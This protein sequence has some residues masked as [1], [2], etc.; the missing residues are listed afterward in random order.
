[1]TNDE[2]VLP[3]VINPEELAEQKVPGF[4]IEQADLLLEDRL[5]LLPDKE[6]Y[7]AVGYGFRNS[8]IAEIIQTDEELQ[9][10]DTI[11]RLI[12]LID[13]N[14]GFRIEAERGIIRL[15]R[16]NKPIIFARATSPDTGHVMGGWAWVRDQV[17]IS[18]AGRF[19]REDEPR[20]AFAEHSIPLITS[21][22][23]IMSTPAQLRRFDDLIER[24]DDTDFVQNGLNWPHVFFTPDNLNT[25]IPENWAHRQDAFQMLAVSTIDALESGFLTTGQRN[26]NNVFTNDHAAFMAR[27]VPFLA[28]MDFTE[29]ETS[30]SW[31]EFDAKRTSVLAWDL[32]LL[33]KID[34]LLNHPDAG[35]ITKPMLKYFQIV[36]QKLPEKYRQPGKPDISAY[37][38]LVGMMIADGKK[39]LKRRLPYG[40]CGEVDPSHI[41][42]RPDDA[43]L[44][45]LLE[46]D[47]PH[48]LADDESEAREIELQILNRIDRLT[49]TETGAIHRYYNDNYLDNA[50]FTY[51]AQDQLGQLYRGE[52]G[53]NDPQRHF[54]FQKRKEICPSGGTAAWVHF[55]YEL[56]TW[57]GRR[58]QETGELQYR[59]LQRHNLL[60]AQALETGENEVRVV[61]WDKL[62]P[63]KSVPPFLTPECYV[64]VGKKGKIVPGPNTP[65]AW[66]TAEKYRALLQMRRSIKFEKAA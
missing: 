44:I 56:S 57:A 3:T 61:I 45:Y 31:E 5:A 46:L 39:E 25:E 12:H 6:I 33:M 64:R 62:E 40:E 10:T 43:A 55:L 28:A 4:D 8:A 29:Y 48:F 23:S 38:N 63:I 32:T 53:P 36:N 9:D 16:K 14:G 24:N 37:K 66:A 34:D 17:R 58:Y 54:N 60:K 19:V 2:Q 47:I 52:L 27:L 11:D 49:D 59:D 26:W 18:D 7:P 22:L 20:V 50:Y 15:P 65:L 30:G 21:L 51:A 41:A 13:N 1:M 35:F 42:F